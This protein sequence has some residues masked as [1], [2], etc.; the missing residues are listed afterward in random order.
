MSIQVKMNNKLKTQI[1]YS[2]DLQDLK[3]FSM[4]CNSL[5]V[6]QR[7]RQEELTAIKGITYEQAYTLMSIYMLGNKASGAQ[8]SRFQFRKQS[9]LNVMLKR[10]EVS[11]LIKRT[12]DK[13]IKNIVWYSLTR[14]G[15]RYYRDIFQME[16]VNRILDTLPAAK[17]K[18]LYSLLNVIRI[19][20]LKALNIDEKD[21]P[22]LINNT[23]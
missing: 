1:N 3:L 18:Q 11:G 20:G 10:L 4:L 7:L 15:Y 16:S 6:L 17:K 9:T 5:E 23:I 19:K 22:P 8:L 2:G 21:C 14:K 12:P 13:Q